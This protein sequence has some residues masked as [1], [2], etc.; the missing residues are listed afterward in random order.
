MA[1]KLVS[2]LNPNGFLAIFLPPLLFES[3]FKTEW[4]LFKKQFEQTLILG[5][6]CVLL[7]S[8]LIMASVKL[9]LNYDDVTIFLIVAILHLA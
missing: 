5:I 1:A 2:E 7:A 3:A 4:H 6:P 9:I 8:L